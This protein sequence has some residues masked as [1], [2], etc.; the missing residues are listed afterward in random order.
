[1]A[2][3]SLF[4]SAL[5]IAYPLL[6]LVGLQY[7]E[8]WIF[9]ALLLGLIILRQRHHAATLLRGLSGV[10][11]VALGAMVLV[12]L[13]VIGTNSETLLRLYPGAANAAMLV[14]F[15]YSLVRPPSLV[16]RFAR[17]KQEN[18]S[19]AAIAYTRRVTQAWC[20]YFLGN[21][22]LAV[23]TAVM[24]SRAV[25]ALYNGLIAYVL[26]GALFGGEW[27]LRKHLLQE[28]NA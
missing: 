8:P 7:F 26:M 12:A 19:P 22:I 27:L 3:G 6:V 28:D 20:L 10:Q 2:S 1:M 23:W 24:A 15:G 11:W 4:V 14:V 13:S 25:W 18:L 16:E 17:L 5:W 9:G 21:G